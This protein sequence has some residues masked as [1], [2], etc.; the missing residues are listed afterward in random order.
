M[1]L[2]PSG[3][4]CANLWKKRLSDC[5]PR[6][7]TNQIRPISTNKNG[8]CM[9]N[10][11]LAF[12]LMYFWFNFGPLISNYIIAIYFYL[13]RKSLCVLSNSKAV[14]YLFL[15]FFFSTFCSS[16][17]TKTNGNVLDMDAIDDCFSSWHCY[18]VTSRTLFVIKQ[19]SYV[20][21]YYG[22][23]TLICIFKPKTKI[24]LPGSVTKSI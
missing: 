18:S 15:F 12:M 10:D 11:G 5:K 20:F 7:A 19:Q 6:N 8:I 16:Y 9:Q 24:S 4:S 17:L 21:F 1:N 22:F 2:L 13:I 3:G 14:F 23:V